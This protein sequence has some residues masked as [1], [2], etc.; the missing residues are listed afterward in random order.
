MKKLNVPNFSELR[1]DTIDFIKNKSLR[2]NNVL[3][4][5]V[6]KLPDRYQSLKSVVESTNSGAD[7]FYL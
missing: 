4:N 5:S 2:K 7:N 1:L 3:T 6:D